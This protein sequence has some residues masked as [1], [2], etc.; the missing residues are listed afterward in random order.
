MTPAQ[1][2]A[3]QTADKIIDR[4][5]KG[6]TKG[7]LIHDDEERQVALA[8]WVFRETLAMMAENAAADHE[9]ITAGMNPG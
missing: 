7:R 4:A 9:R 8:L 3:L 5:Q 1:I 6:V 2:E